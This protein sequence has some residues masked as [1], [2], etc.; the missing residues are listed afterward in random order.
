MKCDVC[1][2]LGKPEDFLDLVHDDVLLEA[3]EGTDIERYAISYECVC[4]RCKAIQFK[5]CYH[6][7]AI[8]M[9]SHAYNLDGIC[10]NCGAMSPLSKRR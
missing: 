4:P 1:G 7:P 2:I 10:T 8:L 6:A 5:E 9:G 3:F